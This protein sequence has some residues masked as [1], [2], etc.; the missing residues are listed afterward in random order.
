MH[1]ITINA[2][3]ATLVLVRTGCLNTRFKNYR[4]MPVKTY[5]KVKVSN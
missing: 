4:D 1:Y 3:N 2:Y 5:N